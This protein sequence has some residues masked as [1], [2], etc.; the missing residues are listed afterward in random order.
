MRRNW[1]RVLSLWLTL[2]MVFTMNF[3]FGAT[4]VYAAGLST[5]GGYVVTEITAKSDTDVYKTTTVADRFNSPTFKG[6]DDEDGVTADA[7]SLIE[8]EEITY[9]KGSESAENVVNGTDNWEEGEKYIAVVTVELTKAAQDARWSKDDTNSTYTAESAQVTRTTYEAKIETDTDKSATQKYD[10]DTND[11]KTIFKTSI[12]SD[13][14]DLDPDKIE[15]GSPKW[16]ISE[17]EN[18]DAIDD[19]D[20]TDDVENKTPKDIYDI[21]GAGNF[22]VV[23]QYELTSEASGA[24]N[25]KLKN[26]GKASVKFTIT[27]PDN[28]EVGD[29][30]L[31][32]DNGDPVKKDKASYENGKL[33]FKSGAAGT[34]KLTA[35]NKNALLEI[36]SE[37]SGVIINLVGSTDGIAV[38][39]AKTHESTND[40]TVNTADENTAVSMGNGTEGKAGK[41]IAAF[42]AK[43]NL[44]DLGPGIKVGTRTKST[45]SFNLSRLVDGV[46]YTAEL[47]NTDGTAVGNSG[48]AKN[49]SDAAQNHTKIDGKTNKSGYTADNITASNS[50]ITFDG[51]TSGESFKLH[52]TTAGVVSANW[53]MYKEL[54]TSSEE[55]TTKSEAAT[56]VSLNKVEDFKF[57]GIAKDIADNFSLTKDSNAPEVAIIAAKTGTKTG[58][59]KYPG[60]G[61]TVPY[62]ADNETWSNIASDVDTA[63]KSAFK[64]TGTPDLS[65]G[66]AFVSDNSVV[67]D[68]GEY[69]AMAYYPGNGDEV[70][71]SVNTIKFKIKPAYVYL[72]PEYTGTTSLKVGQT[73]KPG[74]LTLKVYSDKAGTT[75]SEN[76]TTNNATIKY[77]LNDEEVKAAGIELKES[78]YTLS[79]NVTGAELANAAG[80]SPATDIPGNYTISVNK[81]DDTNYA[82]CIVNTLSVISVSSNT[83]AV[84]KG[85]LA[86]KLFYGTELTEKNID[87]Y[88]VVKNGGSA[89]KDSD[90]KW[91]YSVELN[92]YKNDIANYG[93]N[94]ES[95]NKG[96][97]IY[98]WPE[99]LG[100]YPDKPLELEVIARPVEIEGTTTV[101]S[102][103]HGTLQS[104]YGENSDEKVLIWP[105]DVSGNRLSTDINNGVK[106]EIKDLQDEPVYAEL[107]L[108][109]IDKDSAGTYENVPMM[110]S[111]LSI[112]KLNKDKNYEI[113]KATVNEYVI[114][115]AVQIKVINAN[116]GAQLSVSEN[117]TYIVG[118]GVAGDDKTPTANTS[119]DTLTISM[120]DR[121]N[122][123]D[124][125]VIK[126][127]DT[128]GTVELKEGTHWD[129]NST[130]KIDFYLNKLNTDFKDDAD[131]RINDKTNTFT[132]Y[133]VY[134][135]VISN[136]SK[137]S[138][139]S[140]GTLSADYI[141]PVVYNGNKHV[142]E[143]DT[144]KKGLSRDLDV[145]VYVCVDNANNKTTL[146]K[147][148]D[149]KLSYKNNVNAAYATDKKAPQVIVTGIGQYKGQKLAIPFTILPQNFDEADVQVKTTVIA[150][151]KKGEPKI[152]LTVK[153]G[154]KK[155]AKSFYKVEYF[156]GNTKLT[157]AQI[158][159]A[160][161]GKKLLELTAKV[162][163][164][165]P[166]NK[167]VNFTIGDSA[168]VCNKNGTADLLIYP[169]GSKT[170]N[171]KLAD[172][173]KYNY[174][175][176][177]KTLTTEKVA[178]SAN[179][180]A[181][182]GKTSVDYADIKDGFEFFADK[183]LTD[184]IGDTLTDA[185]TYYLR[186][187]LKNATAMAKY[188]AYKPGV[189]K[190][191]FSA[192]KISKKNVSLT[193]TKFAAK[194]TNE[195]AIGLTTGTLKAGT[196]FELYGYNEI[197][198]PYEIKVNGSE[199]KYTFN[200]NIDVDGKNRDV[201]NGTGSYTVLVKGIHAYSG[202]FKLKYSYGKSSAKSLGIT[203]TIPSFKY[204]AAGYDKS[205]IVL[206]DADGNTVTGGQYAIDSVTW[207]TSKI[208]ENGG[209]ATIKFKYLTG[210]IKANF[211]VTAVAINDDT[212]LYANDSVYAGT[213]DKKS[214]VYLYMVNGDNKV[215][216]RAGK[217]YVL[218][219]PSKNS[220]TQYYV[221][222]TVPAKG[223]ML[224]AGG[225]RR[226]T[227]SVYSKKVTDVK[228]SGL[229][230]NTGYT[231][232]SSGFTGTAN[233]T[234]NS[235]K[236]AYK[237]LGG[238]KTQAVYPA[239]KSV[240][241]KVDGKTE[242][243]P[244]NYYDVEY[245]PVTTNVLD[246]AGNK[247]GTQLA[248]GTYTV[249]ITILDS[250]GTLYPSG[251]TATY[252]Y[253]V[254][255]F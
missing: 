171:V 67:W 121:K 227:Y 78:N 88:A 161:E 91:Y 30:T 155:V 204:N 62:F 4:A 79:A 136:L 133:G 223:S 99:V 98:I 177:L 130:Y 85:T 198:D 169:K 3:G 118:T 208:G 54:D 40:I 70:S 178:A 141:T 33:T 192:P 229:S 220:A 183:N 222:A 184:S 233:V 190:V 75:V 25:I 89:V 127:T 158:A 86:D 94:A 68:A 140:T 26:G 215:K 195:T 236:K 31:V 159:A 253:K 1:K 160:Y 124:S 55:A 28:A 249:T 58:G 82:D 211:T 106:Q 87:D 166:K 174:S 103:R 186:V 137:K 74:D 250:A 152:S 224:T 209:S 37:G 46:T 242:V 235:S 73:I 201:D 128:S 168:Y 170:I 248:P 63:Y 241:A 76:L 64:G 43:S 145:E 61:V 109:G 231:G 110:I 197:G 163:S 116:T 175:E 247:T 22:Y 199:G 42:T 45:V 51:L 11:M 143:T 147:G 221:T 108:T 27:G 219:S 151:T 80:S 77:F 254:S 139:S 213:A 125:Y 191:V 84:T 16:W 7:T 95:Y 164:I 210:S 71:P 112:N 69:V 189:V 237:Y 10:A 20:S 185:G 129:V 131:Y 57:P 8:S 225:T 83:I 90:V 238:G 29:W 38:V 246:D 104:K 180:I 162:T 72:K 119:G 12:K 65:T 102:V 135:P 101:K 24:N 134:T 200:Y 9:Y 13:N 251:T 193:T 149:Y 245:T 176:T 150:N 240:T 167:K 154:S 14:T 187:K 214:N 255:Q 132:I 239:I 113:A 122:M 153:I 196:D 92:G 96:Q 53:V 202:S 228:I 234:Y 194:N 182:V 226:I 218:S 18:G 32:D 23:I 97:K 35:P 172:K 48:G 107:D 19:L 138:T 123:P 41:V 148:V 105:L 49:G 146:T 52:L 173:G 212:V 203:A 34:Y 165:N 156:D 243:I 179:V 181:K 36:D 59:D 252:T 205:K 15:S 21:A 144:N 142:D 2:C 50:V 81:I 207:K 117:Y 114:T 5:S 44:K 39:D 93:A 100:N 217:D 230:S 126:S 120:N 244:S 206:K 115:N 60:E 232:T 216:L 188:E 56:S 17:T 6:T 66:W 111:T 157:P 47:K